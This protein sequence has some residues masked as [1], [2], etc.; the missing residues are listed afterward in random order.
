VGYWGRLSIATQAVNALTGSKGVA[1]GLDQEVDVGGTPVKVRDLLPAN[2]KAV[3][4][5]LD[6]AAQAN[7]AP[8]W[9]AASYG[10]LGTAAQLRPAIVQALK[11]R[12][13][14]SETESKSVLSPDLSGIAPQDTIDPKGPAVQKV[15]LAGFGATVI[16]REEL[17]RDPVLQLKVSAASKWSTLL[18][19]EQLNIKTMVQVI[20][21]RQNEAEMAAT[22]YTPEQR[23]LY[24]GEI[25]KIKRT[26]GG[27]LQLEGILGQTDLFKSAADRR[28]DERLKYAQ[29][30]RDF[31]RAEAITNRDRQDR[32]RCDNAINS[33]LK[34]PKSLPE[35]KTNAAALAQMVKSGKIVRDPYAF[36]M[37]GSP[38]EDGSGEQ[39]QE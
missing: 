36:I 21:A 14:F 6:Q 5:V 7:A 23:A 11:E 15:N 28:A 39:T 17:R 20:E 31:Q 29:S 25:N 9:S 34:N 32:I 8:W 4:A 37:G 2:D 22:K 13:M 27:S 35:H 24:L 26:V 38:G 30:G 1:Y 33:V 18:P 19:E 10:K 16:S 12:L 3:A